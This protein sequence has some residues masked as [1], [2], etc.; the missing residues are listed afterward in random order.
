MSLPIAIVS[1]DVLIQAM[2]STT[3]PALARFAKHIWDKRH[4]ADPQPADPPHCP[5]C[6]EGCPKCQPGSEEETLP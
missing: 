3:D 4:A 6:F 5:E 1:D 2:C